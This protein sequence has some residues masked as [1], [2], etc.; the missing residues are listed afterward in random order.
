MKYF[1]QFVFA[2]I[3]INAMVWLGVIGN[4]GHA[5]AS[6]LSA[7]LIVTWLLAL[8]VVFIS[9]AV[10]LSAAKNGE[11]SGEKLDDFM[12]KA[13][14]LRAYPK[15]HSWIMRAIWTV[16]YLSIIAM[17]WPWVGGLMLVVHW[18][19]VSASWAVIEAAETLTAKSEAM[20]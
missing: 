14:R 19:N 8:V 2:S 16:C 20:S 4:H 5:W 9:S 7:F 3:L 13:E 1:K 11:L 10:A 12:Q 15:A 6:N 18:L 17:G